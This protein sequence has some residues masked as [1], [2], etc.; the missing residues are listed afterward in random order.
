MTSSRNV[1]S[2]RISPSGGALEG[3]Q[4]IVCYT[5]TNVCRAA[6]EHYTHELQ[7]RLGPISILVGSDHLNRVQDAVLAHALRDLVKMSRT[8]SMPMSATVIHGRRVRSSVNNTR[9]SIGTSRGYS[10]RCQIQG[11]TWR[12]C[13]QGTNR[14]STHTNWAITQSHEVTSDES[15]L[16]CASES[17]TPS[18]TLVFGSSGTHRDFLRL[19]SLLP[20]TMPLAPLGLN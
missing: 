3:G 12:R 8:S 7:Q 18:D 20:V 14:L 2:H 19:S 1:P 16:S 6:N 10:F 15:R 13:A 11:E 17:L 4:G 5:S 9:E